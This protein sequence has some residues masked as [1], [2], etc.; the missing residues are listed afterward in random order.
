M[1][2]LNFKHRLIVFMEE[3]ILFSISCTCILQLLLWQ[4]FGERGSVINVQNPMYPTC[5]WQM[6]F[7]SYGGDPGYSVRHS[8]WLRIGRP[9]G[10]ISS[11]GRVKN[12]LFYTSSRLALGFTQ[13]H[14]RW[15]PGILSP[16]INRPGPEADHSPPLYIHFP[17]RLHAVVL[18]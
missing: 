16:G 9:R 1:T 14:I 5:L 2:V 8:G 17:I 3:E 4:T 13:P 10:R 11:P 18:N 15:E 12:F 7:V 6:C